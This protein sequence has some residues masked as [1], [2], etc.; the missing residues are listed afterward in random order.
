[1]ACLLQPRELSLALV[2][3]RRNLK[4]GVRRLQRQGAMLTDTGRGLFDTFLPEG[5]GQRDHGYLPELVSLE[6]KRL[7]KSLGDPV[8]LGS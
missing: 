8:K 5:W 3:C 6:S 1:M 2:Y 7:C 4:H